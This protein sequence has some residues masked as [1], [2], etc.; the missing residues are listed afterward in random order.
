MSTQGRS[1][2]FSQVSLLANNTLYM[3]S[4]NVTNIL[5]NAGEEAQKVQGESLHTF[6]A[7]L[8]T[9]AVVCGLVAIMAVILKTKL[10]EL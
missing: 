6:L 10:P 4:I 2:T 1:F 5:Q 7:S 3:A 8:T 9:S